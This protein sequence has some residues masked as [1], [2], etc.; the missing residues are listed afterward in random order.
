MKV[1]PARPAGALRVAGAALAL[2][3]AAALSGCVDGPGE[4][5]TPTT[6]EPPMT[7]SP[8]P[9]GTESPTPPSG[10]PTPG[11]QTPGPGTEPPAP[12]ADVD[13]MVALMP[14]GE[15]T[16]S[17]YRLVCA[18]G[19]P[20]SGSDHPTA[21]EACAFLA[22]DGAKVLTALPPKN[23]VCTQQYGGPARALVTGTMDG[24]RVQRAFSLTD[25]CQISDWRAA[26]PLLGKGSA[27]GV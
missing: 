15:T 17:T 21:A 24:Q 16:S 27:A 25:G 6:T 9:S 1:R 4:D 3:A 7:T 19:R 2:A 12:H 23:R 13:L 26:E 20:A 14:D 8:G 10:S 22:G 5:T 18:D 11:T